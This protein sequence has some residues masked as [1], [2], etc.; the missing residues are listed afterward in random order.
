MAGTTMNITDLITE[1]G[2]Y[3]NEG[4]NA[5]KIHEQLWEKNEVEQFF[6]RVIENGDLYK[7]VYATIDD[8]LQAFDIDFKPSN[9]V[10]FYPTTTEMGTF[11]VD[12]QI[13]PDQLRNSYMAF[14]AGEG[15]PDKTR[16]PFISW[17][18][19][20]MI[21]PKQR[22]EYEL[23]VAFHGWKFNGGSSAT[24]DVNT[25]TYVR[26]KNSTITNFR[27]GNG[28]MDGI[29]L[30]ILRHIDRINTVTT[31]A[32]STDPA[33]F[34]TQVETFVNAI[35]EKIRYKMDFL[36]MSRTLRDRYRLGRRAKYNA[37]W[38]QE[39][40]LL[41]I[42]NSPMRVQ[43][44]AAMVGSEMVWCTPPTNR[45]R[46]TQ[47]DFTRFDPQKYDRSLK[48][49]ADWKKTLAFDV[50]EFIYINDQGL[51]ITAQEVTDRYTES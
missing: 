37:N 9:G 23:N 38:N 18:I 36:F 22:E 4:Q 35:P 34:C 45:K 47:S 7:S 10:K 11:K 17:V 13:I 50:P 25:T 6:M 24:P 27:M 15:N 41:A 42:D 3:I 5:S 43:G 19:Q 14:L 21:I 12:G 28:A 40:D 46:P 8:V 30:W 44:L 2:V 20:T 26:Q 33:T 31:G 29:R 48:I 39:S 49:L 32:W 1:W 51:T 16:V